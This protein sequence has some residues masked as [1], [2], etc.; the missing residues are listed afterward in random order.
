MSSARP[1]RHVGVRDLSHPH[2]LRADDRNAD[3]A[4][5]VARQVQKRRRRRSHDR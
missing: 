5:D 4:A 1:E 2:E 3:R